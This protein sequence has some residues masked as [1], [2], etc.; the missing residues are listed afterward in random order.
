MKN[1]PYGLWLSYIDT[2]TAFVAIF[3]ILFVFMFV[4]ARTID[5]KS[6]KLVKNWNLAKEKLEQLNAQPEIDSVFGG[7]KL[8]IAEKVLFNINKADISDAGKE[9]IE[10]LSKILAEFIKSNYQYK[11]AF[12]ITIG[13]H[14][15]LTGSDEINFPLSFKRAFNVSEIIKKEFKKLNLDSEN[16]VP[17]A[18]GSKYLRK[19]IQN[20][21][22]YRHRRITIVI[23]I[24][25]NELLTNK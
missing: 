5:E 7:I 12:R 24:L 10:R 1:S 25:S 21:Y 15:D 18:Y 2:M 9:T 20:P 4:R 6:E 22:D 8:T 14:T 23:Q 17:I 16:I 19:D 13:G 3:L 11:K